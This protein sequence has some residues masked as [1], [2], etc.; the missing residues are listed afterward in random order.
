MFYLIVYCI[1][2]YY[3][4]II[5]FLFQFRAAESTLQMGE[6]GSWSIWVNVVN[7]RTLIHFCVYVLERALK[8]MASECVIVFAF[9]CVC[10]SRGYA[11]QFMCLRVFERRRERERGRELHNVMTISIIWHNQDESVSAELHKQILILTS[12]SPRLETVHMQL[13]TDWYQP[14]G[15][16]AGT[17][18]TPEGHSL[19]LHSIF[20]YIYIYLFFLDTDFSSSSTGTNQFYTGEVILQHLSLYWVAASN[21]S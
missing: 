14:A 18:L 5:Y 13:P 11:C 6:Q 15:S 20:A 16:T 1:Q 8:M 21:N 17:T 9:I 4:N 10:L 2:F 19:T 12:P 7:K 3:L